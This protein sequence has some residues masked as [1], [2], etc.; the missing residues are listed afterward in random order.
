MGRTFQPRDQLGQKLG[1]GAVPDLVEDRHVW[2]GVLLSLMG[3][4]MEN[5]QSL[6]H[7]EKTRNGSH[8]GRGGGGTAATWGSY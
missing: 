5:A 8:S 3:T 4:C 1:G 6:S 2:F 7:L